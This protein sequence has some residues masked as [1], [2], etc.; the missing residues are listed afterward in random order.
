MYYQYRTV[1]ANDTTKG[2]G[3]MEDDHLSNDEDSNKAGV[4]PRPDGFSRVRRGSEGDH[5]ELERENPIEDGASFAAVELEQ[6]RNH[7]I[8]VGYQAKHVIRQKS[9]QNEPIVTHDMTG[10]KQAE[11]KLKSTRK[12]ESERT[13]RLQQYLQSAGLRKFRKELS[14]IESSTS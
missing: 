5:M 2:T 3:K 8:G 7:Q 10:S 1:A 6:F 13:S 9:A 4:L 12:P 11:V 14:S